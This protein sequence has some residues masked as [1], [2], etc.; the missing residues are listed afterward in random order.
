LAARVNSSLGISYENEPQQLSL[1]RIEMVLGD[2][3][4]VLAEYE[5]GN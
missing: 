4:F 5:Y 1:C 3:H 2:S